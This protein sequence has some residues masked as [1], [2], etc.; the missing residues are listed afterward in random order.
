MLAWP[1]SSGDIA[2]ATDLYKQV[3][4]ERP[5][6]TLR[7]KKNLPD[8]TI[9]DQLTR[10]EQTKIIREGL[11]RM[12]TIGFAQIAESRL[13]L[14]NPAALKAIKGETTETAKTIAPV[15]NNRDGDDSRPRNNLNFRGESQYDAIPLRIAEKHLDKH[16][17]GLVKF[18]AGRYSP[19]IA[20]PIRAAR[21]I[22]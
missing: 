6:I 1:A 8:S 18:H 15:E 21:P 2:R 20:H 9:M 12:R 13:E 5:P 11:R 22:R 7:Q 10:E 17:W 14:L 3:I 4:A 19:L 16:F